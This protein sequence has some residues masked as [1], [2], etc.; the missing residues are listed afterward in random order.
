MRSQEAPAV[1]DA[2][3]GS[4]N[5]P[6]SPRLWGAGVV[7]PATA[8]KLMPATLNTRLSGW[9]RLRVTGIS[10]TAPAQRMVTRPAYEPGASPAGSAVTLRT[11]GIVPDA[12][13]I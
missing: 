10:W 3:Q 12:G 4:P 9:A 6:E 2:F 7:P 8:E 13:A 5:A 11:E 1:T